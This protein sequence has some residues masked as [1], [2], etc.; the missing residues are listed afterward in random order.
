MAAAAAAV[1]ATH[2]AA[3]PT[4]RPTVRVC[5]ANAEGKSPSELLATVKLVI[6]WAYA[7]HPLCSSDIEVVVLDQKAKDQALN[8]Q[9]AEGCKVLHQDYPVEIPGV[10]LTLGIMNKKLAANDVVVKEMG[11]ANRCIIRGIMITK[12]WWMHDDKM[13]VECIKLSK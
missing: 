1:Q 12:I 4:Q 2:S 3:Q 7:V 11:T 13:Q 9:D 10:P 6:Q 5:L 8:Q